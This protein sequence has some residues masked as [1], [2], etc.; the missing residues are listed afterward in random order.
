MQEPVKREQKEAA[1]T[2]WY[3]SRDYHP[4]KQEQK[5]AAQTNW[6]SSRDH[7]PVKQEQKEAAETNWYSSRGYEPM[8]QEHKET[9]EDA[10]YRVH[11]Y[12]EKKKEKSTSEGTWYRDRDF[13]HV[14]TT[15]AARERRNQRRHGEKMRGHVRGV[16]PETPGVIQP[17]SWSQCK[18]R[19]RRANQR[20]RGSEKGDDSTT[21]EWGDGDYQ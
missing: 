5:E 13:E 10:W 12:Q 4:V 7:E 1:E 19:R 2:S 14:S 21:S 15:G 16:H 8:K 3:N 11:D 18:K 17:L 9:F 6:Y 20:A